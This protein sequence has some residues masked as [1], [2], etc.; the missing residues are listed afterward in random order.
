T[1]EV[2]AEN[3]WK[4]D[5]NPSD[6]SSFTTA[7]LASSRLTTLPPLGVTETLFQWCAGGYGRLGTIVYS[8]TGFSVR[9]R[10]SPKPS[11]VLENGLSLNLEP[12]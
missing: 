9:L 6:C 12:N 8:R 3:I 7:L 11:S 10:Y 4:Q 1:R 5:F 2:W